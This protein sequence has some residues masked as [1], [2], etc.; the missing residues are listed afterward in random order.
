MPTS[1]VASKSAR[2]GKGRF[3]RELFFLYFDPGTPLTFICRGVALAGSTVRRYYPNPVAGPSCQQAISV[4]NLVEHVF[5]LNE[6]IS[7]H[8]FE[9]KYVCDRYPIFFWLITHIRSVSPHC[10]CPRCTLL[11]ESFGLRITERIRVNGVTWPPQGLRWGFFLRVSPG[12][13]PPKRG[14]S[15]S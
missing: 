11:I 8:R 1:T 3:P 15:S 12:S 14:G 2:T 13:M 6:S 5:L 10:D 4:W 7:M 9:S